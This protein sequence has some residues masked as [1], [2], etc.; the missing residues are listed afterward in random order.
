MVA[1]SSA[2]RN[3]WPSGRICTAVPILMRLVRAA[4][5]LA[6]VNGADSSDRVG[7]MWISASQTT[8]RPQSSAAAICAKELLNAVACECASVDQILVNIPNSI[9]APERNSQHHY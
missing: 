7:F 2:N 3:G 9:D 1:V 8:S 6:T 4:I 5:A